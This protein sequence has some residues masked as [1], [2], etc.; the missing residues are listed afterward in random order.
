[1]LE[2]PVYRDRIEWEFAEG[3]LNGN[4]ALR[5]ESAVSELLEISE[6]FGWDNQDKV[7]WSRVNFELLGTSKGGR[8]PRRVP[9]TRSDCRDHKDLLGRAG[10]GGGHGLGTKGELGTKE[11]EKRRRDRRE[12]LRQKRWDRQRYG[13]TSVR[14]RKGED[15]EDES[16]DSPSGTA[17]ED[18]YNPFPGRDGLVKKV[19]DLNRKRLL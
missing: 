4:R 15:L 7:G 6:R 1:M 14:G 17:A 3:V 8:I 9:A 5:T 2:D 11:D 13:V 19:I 10:R 12:R 16:S 18:V